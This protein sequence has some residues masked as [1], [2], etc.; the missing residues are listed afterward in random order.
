MAERFIRV[1]LSDAAR[2]FRPIA[3]EPGVPLLDRSDANSKILFRWLGGLVAEP[4]WEGDS[5]NFFVRDDHGGRLEEVVCSPASDE[6]LKGPLKEDLDALADRLEKAKPETSTERGVHKIIRHWFAQLTEDENRTDRDNYFFKYRDVLGRW[7]LVWCWGYQRID[8]VPAAVAVCT[9]PDCCLLFVRRPGQSPRCPSCE[10]ALVTG[11]KKKRR[12]RK[13]GILVGVLLFLLGCLLMYWLLTHNRL[14][15]TP[16]NWTGPAGS[17]VE[18]R[19]SKPGLFGRTDVTQRAVAVV[20]D[21]RVLRFDHFGNMATALSPGKTVVTFYLG[22]KSTSATVTV[23][24]A[25]NPKKITIQPELVELGIGTTAHLRLVGEYDDGTTADLTDAAEWEGKNDGIV[26]AHGGFLE[27]LAEG[28][29][30][31]HARYRASPQDEYLDAS[32]NVSVAKVDFRS[33]EMAVDPDPVPVGRASRLHIDAVSDA[34]KKYSVLESSRLEFGVDP[35]YIATVQGRHVEGNHPGHGVMQATFDGRVT[36][37]L[38][39][40]VALGAGV[41]KLVV[42]PEQLNMV[43]GEITDLSIASPSREPIRIE[44]SDPGVVEVTRENRLV[45]RGEGSAQ[46]IVSQAGESRTVDVVVTKANVGSIAIKPP[47]VVVPV[48]HS[49]RVRVMGRIE[50]ER[51]IELAPDLISCE[52]RPSPRYADYDDESM[53]L[54]GIL[55]TE[56]SSPQSLALRYSK[57]VAEAPVEVVIAP[58]RME[59]TP[60][61]T[62]DVP[63]GQV[64][65][66]DAW[67]NYRGG[68]RV[69]VSGDRVQWQTDPADGSVPGLEFRAGKVAALEAGAGPLGVWGTYLGQDSDRVTFN[70]VEAAP[71]ELKLEVDRTLRLANEPGRLILLGTGP[72]GDVE[73]VPELAA[74]ESS[75]TNVVNV[76]AATGAF[77][78]G[79]PGEAAITARHA[80]A[81]DP[82]SIKLTVVDPAD[83]RLA[84]QPRSLEL[85][86]DEVGRLD[87]LLR[88]KVGDEVREARMIGPGVSYSIE[89]PEAVRWHAPIIVGLRPAEEFEVT[90]SYLPYLLRPAT[91]K[92]EVLAEDPT[93]IRVVPSEASLA[94]GQMLPLAVEEQLPGS[95][96]WREVRAEAIAWDVPAGL[97][98]SPATDGLRPVVT[99]PPGTRGRFVLKAKYRG[100]EATSNITT[101]EPALDPSD[102]SVELVLQREPE[103]H[104]LPVGK[105]QRY[106][107][108]LRKGNQQEPAAEILWPA[109]FQN[110]YVD[111]KAPVLEAKQAGYEQWLRA[112]VGGR[113]VRW[114]THTIDPFRPGELPPRREDQPVEVV[115]LS[116]QGPAVTFPVGARFHDFRIEARYADGFTRMVT[117]KATM[118]TDADFSGAPVSFS[119]GRMIGV[120]PGKTVVHAD[121]DGVP[122]KEG[123]QVAVTADVD[124]DKIRLEPA[125][126]DILPGETI[127]MDAE[128]FKN[129][130]SIGIITGIGDLAWKS[131]NEAAVGV[132]GP[133]VTG[134]ELGQGN[135]TARLGSVTSEPAAV[136]VVDSIDALLAVDQ[137]AIQMRVGESRR[138]GFDLV[139]RRGGTDFSRQCDVT[140]ALPNVVRYVPETHSLVGMSPGVSAVTF[141]WGDQLA[142]TTVQVL[143]SGTLTGDVIIEP[144]TAILSPGQALDMRVFLLTRDGLRIDRTES[145]VLTSSAPNVAIRSTR[146]C[147]TGPGTSEITARLPEAEVPGKALVTVDNNPITDLVVE[148]SQMALSVGDLARLRILGTSAS[149][150]HELFP[151]PDLQVTSGG[152]TPQAIQIVGSEHVDAVA[153]GSADVAVRWQNRLSRNVPV[154]VT[155]DPLTGLT[156]DPVRATIQPGQPLT[157]QVTGMRGGRRR[158]LGPEDGVQLFVGQPDVADVTGTMVV[159][160]NPGRTEVIAQLGSQRAEAVLNVVPGTGSVVVG[161]G[162]GYGHIGTDYIIREGRRYVYREGVGYVLVDDDRVVVDGGVT[163]VIDAPPAVGV[164]GLRFVPDVVRMGTDSP[165]ARVRVFEVLANGTLGR[166]VSSDPALEFSTPGNVARVERTPEGPLIRPVAPG[167]TRIAAKVGTSLFAEP[168]LLV[169]VGDVVTGTA[170]LDVSPDPLDLWSGEARKFTSVTVTPGPG[171]FPLDVSYSIGLPA[172]QG[173]VTAEPDGSLRG[174]SGGVTQVTIQVVEPGTPYDGLTTTATVQVTGADQLWI[175]PPE[176]SLKVG[177]TTPRFAVMARGADG[178]QYPVPAT[179]DSMDTNVL[180]PEALLPGQFVAASLGSTQVRG[181]YRNREVF[182]TVTVTGERFL[183]VN[184]TLNEGAQD[185]SV[186]IE[187]LAAAS[188]GPLEYRTYVAGQAPPDGWQPAEEAGA[189]RRATLQSPQIPYG[190][191]SARYSLIIEA[192]S[193]VSGAVQEYPFTFR[194]APSIEQ[195][196]E[197]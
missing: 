101:T 147:A 161:R 197:G 162:P 126:V 134:L 16:G 80:A 118:T 57:L 86:V 156:L 4:E 127:T 124:L 5:V 35:S 185:F 50:G 3:V 178:G 192:R 106:S 146:A 45:G 133:A 159:G 186:G 104:Y 71:V 143:P 175:E 105:Q 11:K 75:D 172:G 179:L 85:A 76:D 154:T 180:R 97:L 54:H 49:Q 96:E 14:I 110:E 65:A 39:F 157:Y 26:F 122:T 145:A 129:D 70:S 32:A 66:I 164:G 88:A 47:S 113:N 170:R 25:R 144:A 8:I 103:G 60:S 12:S 94:A 79:T 38:E 176:A 139:I 52:K 28:T 114:R 19:V 37:S 121:F 117:K 18:F 182:A 51:N 136:S 58:L 55:P 173:V 44:S 61:G 184:T 84:F 56:P 41:D 98:W 152:E 34:G 69:L 151:Q 119:E 191:R 90:A 87:L 82:A 108:V 81:A 116:D 93:S 22:D 64:A 177:E 130:K 140:P 36:G 149:G 77:R 83:A 148:P 29:S 153:P 131:D 163:G 135:V 142:S 168:E 27:G 59:L 89:R 160:R 7:R 6:D 99:V 158:V 72:Q 17:R 174:L 111:W 150:T 92:V 123:L 120:R 91:A 46:A 67:A 194:L 33:L 193:T 43:V 169:Q 141:A 195:T 125:P 155:Y 30:T 62:V 196:D 132:S 100:K 63:L 138:I 190:P 42:A 167:E 183:D 10:A 53:Q 21:P 31:V 78:A 95:Q 187:V 112:E 13:W 15:A 107:I 181:L 171:Q 189:Y 24:A 137:E 166:D 1:D 128:G 48:D 9:D 23:G 165:G 115:I 73:L 20:A 2:D 68:H 40:D 188:E 109:R 74:F 102:P